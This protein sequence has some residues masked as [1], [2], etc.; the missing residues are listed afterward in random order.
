MVANKGTFCFLRAWHPDPG[1]TDALCLFGSSTWPLLYP[2]W[3]THPQAHASVS[4]CPTLRR[5][6]LHIDC[7]AVLCP[8]LGFHFTLI[9]FCSAMEH[10]CCLHLQKPGHSVCSCCITERDKDRPRHVKA[11]C[12]TFWVFNFPLRLHPPCLRTSA[13][14]FGKKP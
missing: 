13:S 1:L 7:F 4:G 11:I 9:A 2:N 5:D 12:L 14:T 3:P 8:H 6:H 10:H